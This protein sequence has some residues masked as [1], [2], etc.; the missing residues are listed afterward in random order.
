MKKGLVGGALFEEL[1][2][3]YIGPV[4]G[5]DISALQVALNQAKRHDQPVLLHIFTQKGHGFHPAEEDPARFH[6]PPKVVYDDD[7]EMHLTRSKQVSYT[8][9]AA[10]ALYQ[11]MLFDPRVCVVCAAMAQGNGLEKIRQVFRRRHL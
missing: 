10:A 11:Q 2:F 6:A 9:I 3:H 5:H 7:G 4:N 1:G 8:N